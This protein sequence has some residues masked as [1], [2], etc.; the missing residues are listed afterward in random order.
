MTVHPGDRQQGGEEGE[1]GKTGVV[2]PHAAVH[3]AQA[4]EAHDE[5]AGDDEETQNH[6]QQ[7]K[8]I[9]GLQWI[10][11]NTAKDRGHR[12]EDDG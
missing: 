2:D 10:K 8:R 1:D 11:T 4:S 7:V 3:V 5:D 6:P 9:T 12:N